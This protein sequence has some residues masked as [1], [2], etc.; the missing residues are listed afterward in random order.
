MLVMVV[1][2]MVTEW[3]TWCGGGSGGCGGGAG[4]GCCGNDYDGGQGERESV[5]KE[6]TRVGM[7]LVSSVQTSRQVL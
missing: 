3:C 7:N 6:K 2:I 4:V 5:W 1:V